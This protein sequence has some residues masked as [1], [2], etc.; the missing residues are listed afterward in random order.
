MRI[1]DYIIIGGIIWLFVDLAI[2]SEFQSIAELKGHKSS[3][4]FWYPFLFPIIGY[5]MIA[6][7]PDL[8]AR[9]RK[10]VP[11]SAFPSNDSDELPDL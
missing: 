3:K 4:Y 8:H 9:P 2:S 6:A 1:K 5:F 7:L 11:A 10:R